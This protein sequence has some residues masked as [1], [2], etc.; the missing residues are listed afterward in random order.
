MTGITKCDSYYKVRQKVCTS[1]DGY[2][3]MQQ[4]LQSVTGIIKCEKKLLQSATGI[5]KWDNYYKVRHK[6]FCTK[7]T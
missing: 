1:C 2:Y 3:K 7:V 5:T 6:S 4:V